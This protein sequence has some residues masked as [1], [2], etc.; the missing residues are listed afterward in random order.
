M[1]TT[2]RLTRKAFTLI[3][4][5]VVIA[6]I[7]ILIGLLLPAVQKAREASFRMRCQNNLKQLGIAAHQMNEV[8]D[9]LPPFSGPGISG[10]G[11]TTQHVITLAAPAY[12]GF[13]WSGLAFFLPYI[14][15][16][17]IYSQMLLDPTGTSFP[18][19]YLGGQYMRVIPTFICPSDTSSPGGHAGS[20]SGSADAFGVSNYGLNFMAFG[21]TIT[22]SPEGRSVIPASF[23]DGLSNTIFFAEMYGTCGIDPKGNINASTI[24]GSLWVD[25]NPVYRPGFCAGPGNKTGVAG[26]PPCGMFQVQPL[27]ARTCDYTRASSPHPGGINV[28]LGDGS[29]RFLSAEISPTTWANACDPRDGNPLGSDW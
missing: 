13:N 6:I 26:S 17:T 12:N 9:A 14:E 22:G 1:A 3:E 29:V 27:A 10:P 28:G 23:P 4:L 25:S 8:N 18:S 2:S 7:A 21:N 19:N 24:Y 16:D 20:T 11:S 15:Q 5:L